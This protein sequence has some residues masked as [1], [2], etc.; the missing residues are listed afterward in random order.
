[1]ARMVSGHV[2]LVRRKRGPVYYLKTRVPEQVVAAAERH[3]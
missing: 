2:K 1:M 3:R